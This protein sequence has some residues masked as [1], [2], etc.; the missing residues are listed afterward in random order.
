MSQP[1]AWGLSY[2]EIMGLCW[3]SYKGNPEGGGPK[4][5]AW[6]IDGKQ[7]NVDNVIIE[8][9]FAAIVARGSR[10]V[11][12]LAG[13]DDAMDW[14]DNIS[15][16]LLG[17]SNQYVKAVRYAK[18]YQPDVVVG[19][20]LGGGMASYTS[21]YADMKAATINAA[22]LNIN[23]VS[24]IQILRRRRNVINY[25]VPGE[26]LHIMDRAMP[27]MTKIGTTHRVGSGGGGPVEKH[28]IK[29]LD[30]FVEP[31]RVG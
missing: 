23:P 10:S 12:A 18:R 7:W 27:T 29:N 22:P 30:G 24:G 17:V 20:S 4:Q 16:G 21:I 1:S 28:L 9:S 19:H 6:I 5:G 31:T 11:L 25:V 26:V 8:G 2:Q 3:L 14:V 15:Q 13:T